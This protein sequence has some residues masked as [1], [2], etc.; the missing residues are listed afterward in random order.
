MLDPDV[1]ARVD[2]GNVIR[3]ARNWAAGAVAFHRAA[4]HMKPVLVDGRVGLALAPHGKIARVLT[5]G[6]AG[7]TIRDVEVLMTPEDLAELVIEDLP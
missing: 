6:F 1:V 5:F 7:A 2:D 3:G 4:Q